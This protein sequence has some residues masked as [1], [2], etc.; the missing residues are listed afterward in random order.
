MENIFIIS[1]TFPKWQASCKIFLINSNKSDFSIFFKKEI[2]NSLLSS[3]NDIGDNNGKTK[4][5]K[6]WVGIFWDSGLKFS[7]LEFFVPELSR[8][9]LMVGNFMG[10]NFPGEGVFLIPYLLSESKQRK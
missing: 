6:T 10:V 8:G 9:N 4:C 7:R 5:L 2:Q 1:K 3:T